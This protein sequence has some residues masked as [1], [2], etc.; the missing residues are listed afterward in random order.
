MAGPN[1]ETTV[2]D[3]HITDSV[4]RL[5]APNMDII[6]D[7]EAK[8]FVSLMVVDEFVGVD[9]QLLTIRGESTKPNGRF[10]LVAQDASNVTIQMTDSGEDRLPPQAQAAIS[11][12]LQAGRLNHSSRPHAFNAWSA[13]RS[14]IVPANDRHIWLE[15]DSLTYDVAC[16]MADQAL[17]GAVRPTSSW[18]VD[19]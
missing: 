2:Y 8:G 14:G 19:R 15:N 11:H 6:G 17:W 13:G 4:G 1:D 16:K 3:I 12:A 9:P 18:I 7:V 10:H 5:I